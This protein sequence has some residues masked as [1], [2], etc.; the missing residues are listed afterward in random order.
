MILEWK[1]QH[2]EAFKTALKDEWIGTK[3]INIHISIWKNTLK[4]IV[5]IQEKTILYIFYPFNLKQEKNSH[6][7]NKLKTLLILVAFDKIE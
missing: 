3:K 7:L 1:G 2:A 6:K 5:I 4:K